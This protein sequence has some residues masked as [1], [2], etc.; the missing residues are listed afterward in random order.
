MSPRP[1]ALK[2]SRTI[3]STPASTPPPASPQSHEI[4]MVKSHET[5]RSLKSTASLPSMTQTPFQQSG[6]LPIVA[7]AAQ[8]TNKGSNGLGSGSTMISYIKPT[9]TGDEPV[10]PEV[11]KA[12]VDELGIRSGGSASHSNSEETTAVDAGGGVV[13]VRRSKSSDR[14]S[15]PLVSPGKPLSHVRAFWQNSQSGN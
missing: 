3:G 5:G 1:P 7:D 9:K 15:S 12:E 11:T 14:S 6:P 2:K 8:T 13:P 10:L 4:P